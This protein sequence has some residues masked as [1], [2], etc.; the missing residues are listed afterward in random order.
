MIRR[1]T[2]STALTS[3][4]LIPSPANVS[5]T[6]DAESDKFAA[7]LYQARRQ[8]RRIS[9]RPN[10]GNKAIEREVL[11]SYQIAQSLGFNG[12]LSRLGALAA[13]SRVTMELTPTFPEAPS[14][15]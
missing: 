12:R 1:S 15:I 4:N 10:K 7:H 8:Y 2:I 6:P 11:S 13:D 5:N 14:S 9:E 3:T